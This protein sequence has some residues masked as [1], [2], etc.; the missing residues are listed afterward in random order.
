MRLASL[1]LAL[2]CAAA[3]G[4]CGGSGST[5]SLGGTD[6]EAASEPEGGSSDSESTGEGKWTFGCPFQASDVKAIL[7]DDVVE[8]EPE[9][10]SIGDTA[11]CKFEAPGYSVGEVRPSVNFTAF[12][13]SADDTAAYC[14]VI[15]ADPGEGGVA[16]ARPDWGD[17][18]CQVLNDSGFGVAEF[19]SHGAVVGI[20]VG[21]VPPSTDSIQAALDEFV[22]LV[23]PDA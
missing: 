20:G 14:D 6:R 5:E 16:E 7:G 12:T 10:S 4:A 17:P 23:G 15:E 8:V 19:I 13:Q 2:L 21:V 3:L 18:A 22:V 9:P 11:L 1:F